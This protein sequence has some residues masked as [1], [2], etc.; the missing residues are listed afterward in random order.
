MKYYIVKD[1]D[2]LFSLVR[3]SKKP[4]EFIGD[5]PL[6]INTKDFVFCSIIEIEGG[7]YTAV[8][9]QGLKDASVA[10]ENKKDLVTSEY[11]KAG[12]DL[13]TKVYE[14]YMTTD[15][16]AILADLETYKLMSEKPQLYDFEQTFARANAGRFSKGDTLSNSSDIKEYADAMLSKVANYSIYRINRLKQRDDAI[17]VILGE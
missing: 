16:D 2:G 7:L 17:A 12:I 4:E 3:K 8:L 13:Y 6:D 1:K 10:Y 11:H 15:K 9:D 5:W 14:T